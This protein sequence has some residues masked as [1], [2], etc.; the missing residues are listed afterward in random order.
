MLPI[1]WYE[2]GRIR[3]E[4]L[5]EHDV[6]TD[7][8]QFR[9]L[10]RDRRPL[11]RLGIGPRLD[12]IG[13]LLLQGG[14]IDIGFGLD[15]E[16]L[17]DVC[18]RHGGLRP[19]RRHRQ[20]KQRQGAEHESDAVRLIPPTHQRYPAALIALLQFGVAFLVG[21]EQ[22]LQT[23][24][25]ILPDLAAQVLQFPIA[26]FDERGA[27]GDALLDGAQRRRKVSLALRRHHV[28]VAVQALPQPCRIK[29]DAAAV[30]I[31]VLAAA[32]GQHGAGLLELHGLLRRRQRR[33]QYRNYEQE[34][35][36]SGHART[37]HK[38]G[39]DGQVFCLIWLRYRPGYCAAAN[40]RG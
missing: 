39:S 15:G 30:V 10:R 11:L 40:R 31:D 3:E 16:F 9:Q 38:E 22:A 29:I 33:R 12:A 32:R 1:V 5:V 4:V 37:S 26:Q 7:L 19:P 14:Q 13:S 8:R 18:A 6:E 34:K 25:G 21:V 27:R 35:P 36:D 2:A 23:L 28:L 24:D 17:D 20:G